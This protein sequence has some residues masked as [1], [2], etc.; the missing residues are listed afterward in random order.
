MTVLSREIKADVAEGGYA[1]I[2][3]WRKSESTLDIGLSI[4][5]VVQ[6]EHLLPNQGIPTVQTLRPRQSMVSVRNQ[7]SG[8]FG[9][10]EFPLHTD[11]A[12]WARPPRYFILRA[13]AGSAFVPTTMLA[14]SAIIAAVGDSIFRRALAQPRQWRHSSPRCLLPLAFFQDGVFGL[15]WDSLFLNPVNQAAH[16]VASVMSQATWKEP[17]TAH[18][19]LTDAGDTLIVDNWRMLHGRGNVPSSEAS[20][21]LERVYLSEISL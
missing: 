16:E 18:I 5:K 11:L 4:G 6:I 14:G 9:F 10:N 2:R 19:T 1:V 15:R 21:H 13:V 3:G 20:R 12:H 7:Y 8:S 17:D